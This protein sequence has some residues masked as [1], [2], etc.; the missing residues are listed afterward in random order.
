[1]GLKSTTSATQSFLPGGNTM[2]WEKISLF[3]LK[4]KLALTDSRA[5]ARTFPINPAN[6]SNIPYANLTHPSPAAALSQQELTAVSQFKPVKVYGN[7]QLTVL[8]KKGN[9]DI[10][11]KGCP[12][13]YITEDP[14]ISME[15]HKYLLLTSQMLLCG[16]GCLPNFSKL[17]F[18][19]LGL[20]QQP[21]FISDAKL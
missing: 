15:D 12:N 6:P 13:K 1:M 19:D 16:L 17:T 14:T 3:P 4:V 8:P 18:W 11:L 21:G 9:F 2:P 5:T 10:A 7:T 20:R